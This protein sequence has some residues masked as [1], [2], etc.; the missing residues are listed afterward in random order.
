MC[1][2]VF[3]LFK[4]GSC[5]NTQLVPNLTNDEEKK[6]VPNFNNNHKYREQLR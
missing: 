3:S 2:K 6:P 4:K 5:R 1:S